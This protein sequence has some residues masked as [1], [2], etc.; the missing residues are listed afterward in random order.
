MA[1]EIEKALSDWNEH[2]KKT[3]A[4]LKKNDDPTD[5][6]SAKE[7]LERLFR[8]FDKAEDISKFNGA[9]YKSEREL[10]IKRCQRNLAI[11]SEGI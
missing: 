11:L 9:L 1:D 7:Y 8:A 2:Y 3:K 4:W 10:L 6:I 5:P